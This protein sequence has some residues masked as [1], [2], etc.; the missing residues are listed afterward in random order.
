[1]KGVFNGTC[2]RC[3]IFRPRC[4]RVIMMNG[5]KRILCN[6]CRTLLRGRFRVCPEHK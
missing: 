6:Y 1:M 3:E 4:A 2:G 5:E